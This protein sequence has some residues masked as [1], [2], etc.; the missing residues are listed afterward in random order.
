MKS[1]DTGCTEFK[2]FINAVKA[3]PVFTTGEQ[4]ILAEWYAQMNGSNLTKR[5]LDIKTL[6]PIT[7]WLYAK[8]SY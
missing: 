2:A 5:G 3:L 8:V 7:H 4:Q 1:T 6:V